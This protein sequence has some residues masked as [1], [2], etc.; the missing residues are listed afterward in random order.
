MIYY[1]QLVLAVA[2]ELGVAPAASAPVAGTTVEDR[3]AALLRAAGQPPAL[4]GVSA[5]S[6]LQDLSTMSDDDLSNLS[7]KELDQ[8]QK[9]Y[10]L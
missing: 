7:S 5:P 10:G 9:L 3:K 4:G 6:S 1:R 8:L 2:K